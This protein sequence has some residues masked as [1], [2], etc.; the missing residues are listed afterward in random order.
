MD[1]ALKFLIGGFQLAIQL[2]ADAHFMRLL[3]RTLD[4]LHDFG[5]ARRPEN[6]IHRAES[7]TLDHALFLPFFRNHNQWRANSL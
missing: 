4:H 7:K 6:H 1:F 2:E 5:I 3:K